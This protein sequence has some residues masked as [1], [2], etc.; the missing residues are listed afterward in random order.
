MI[1]ERYH[2]HTRHEVYDAVKA[3]VAGLAA[4]VS[5]VTLD[6]VIAWLTFLYMCFLVGEKVW[7]FVQWMRTRRTTPPVVGPPPGAAE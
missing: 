2:V 7:K 4:W 5:L 6:R 1:D 3:G